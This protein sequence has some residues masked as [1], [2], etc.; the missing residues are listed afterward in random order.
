MDKKTA[1]Q[2]RQLFTSFAGVMQDIKR[3]DS[4][5][6]NQLVDL[7]DLTKG[8]DHID[9]EDMLDR[10]EKVQIE[11]HQDCSEF[12]SSYAQIFKMLPVGARHR[13]HEMQAFEPFACIVH[14]C[15]WKGDKV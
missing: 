10:C 6:H 2:I 8:K 13:N 12:M 11:G 3:Q 9:L 5:L 1:D 15:S 7:F 4:V 14:L